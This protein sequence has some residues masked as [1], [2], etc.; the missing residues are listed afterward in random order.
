MKI[1][2]QKYQGTG[3]DFIFIDNRNLFFPINDK[4]F[5][6]FLCDRRF[7]IGADGLILYQEHSGSDGKMVYYNSDGNQSTMCGNG[8]RCF[9]QYMRD[10]GIVKKNELSFMAIDGMHEAKIDTS[11]Q[12]VS[13]KM[14]DVTGINA[15]KENEFEL[16]TGSPHYV[17]NTA[18][19][20]DNMEIV[21]QA[22][23]IRYNDVY[24]AEGINVNYMHFADDVLQIRTYERGVE[25]ETYSC[26]TGVTACAL[27]LHKDS[28]MAT[29]D[30]KI[31]TKGGELS[32]RFNKIA[33]QVFTNI[34][35]TGPAKK[36]FS[37]EIN[38]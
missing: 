6:A 19:E 29:Y 7:G 38:I 1:N 15:I 3:N 32:V 11:T 26:G 31:N 35:L 37:G 9:A 13:L 4:K 14:V 8:G 20:I 22:K 17:V 16:N 10:N 36:V 24:T 21:T 34:W 27:A 25:D 28:E 33:D 12:T 18:H 30:V 23:F 5:I 2:F